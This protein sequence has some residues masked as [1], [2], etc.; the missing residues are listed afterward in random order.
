M[1]G[2]KALVDD[3]KRPM[4]DL[5]YSTR[6]PQGYNVVQL[7]YDGWFCVIRVRFGVMQ[8]ITANG[9]VRKE[10]MS[11]NVP[12]ATLVGEWIYGTNWATSS[13]LF[14]SVVLHQLVDIEGESFIHD[15]MIDMNDALKFFIEDHLEKF[16]TI[17]FEPINTFDIEAWHDLWENNVIN[18]SYEGLVFKNSE[19]SVVDQ[20]FGR[21]KKKLSMEYVVMG[22]KEGT[23]RLEGTLG[24]IVGGL[25][26]NGII[27][28]VCTVGGGFTDSQRDYIWANRGTFIG[29]VME[30][31][32]KMLFDSGA[33][34]HP[35]FLRFREDKVA[36]DCKWEK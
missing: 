24:A 36:N 16:H 5:E 6:S 7:K 18:G 33:L 22:F 14:N 25:Y 10:V 9:T 20:K 17:K 8:L 11:P 35:A 19:L 12:N 29:T 21:M 26:I 3:L 31:T 15:K 27:R 4:T 30:V 2:Y 23:G 13:N 34:R 1:T 28:Q 32:G